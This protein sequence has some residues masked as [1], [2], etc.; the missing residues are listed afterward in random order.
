MIFTGRIHKIAGI[1]LV[2]AGLM[3]VGIILGRRSSGPPVT[4]TLRVAVTPGEQSK[5]VS[6]YASGARFKY[7]MG[8]QSGVKPVLAQKLSIKSVP[9]SSLL[10]AAVR[11]ET[12]EQGERY[13]DS[14]AETLL[15]LCGRE[16]QVTLVTR[17]VR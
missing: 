6:G 8:K 10:D 11:V 15:G 4:V 17:T 3:V 2:V 13:A 14:F 5:L 16:E 12:K 9:N 7:L 1:A